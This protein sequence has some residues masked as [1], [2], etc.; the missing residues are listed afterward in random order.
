MALLEGD[1]D[2][3]EELR[4]QRQ[5]QPDSE[6]LTNSDFETFPALNNIWLQN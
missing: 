3:K 4:I 1:G 2:G 5:L 6:V